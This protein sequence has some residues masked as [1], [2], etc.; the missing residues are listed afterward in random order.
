[1]RKT[2]LAAILLACAPLARAQDSGPQNLFISPCGEPFVAPTSAPYPIVNWFN[3][4]DANHDGKLDAVEFTNDS[5]RFFAVLDRN[6]DGF[7]DFREVNI[8]EHVFVPEI[9]PRNGAE[10]EGLVVRVALQFDSG[11]GGYG[12][13]GSNV[14]QGAQGPLE[15]NPP[16]D[17]NAPPRQRLDSQQGAVP[18]SL[19]A[20]PEPVRAADRNLDGKVSLKEFRDQAARRFA[21][22]D[23][24]MRG[25][26]VLDQL[27]QTDYERAA[28]ARRK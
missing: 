25:Y 21:A 9:L 23:T 11:G 20:A 5:D 28:K 13:G 7:I 2:V 12:T 17:P 1:M 24:T 3:G 26:L 16:T 22:L 27:P 15:V 19:F 8:Y 18:F 6:H 14:A 10:A 4:A